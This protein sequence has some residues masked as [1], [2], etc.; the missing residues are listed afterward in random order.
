M[1]QKPPSKCFNRLL[2]W[3]GST[4][5][6]KG[7]VK[8]RP[9]L[10]CHPGVRIVRCALV[11]LVV[12]GTAVAPTVAAPPASSPQE[13]VDFGR[14][15][16]PILAN[17]CFDCHGPDAAQRESGLRLDEGESAKQPADSGEPAIVPGHSTQSELVRR[18]LSEDPDAVMP[19]VESNKRLTDVEKETLKRWIDAGAHYEVHWSFQKPMEP[20]LPR[21]SNDNWPRNEID[22]F[23]LRRLE[24][25]QLDP[26]AEADRVT[27]IRRLSLD[28]T[29]LPPSIAEVD[30]FLGDNN[31]NA[32]ARLVD[33]LLASPHYGEKMAEGWLDLARFGDTNG[34]QDDAYRPSWPYRDQVIAAFNQNQPFDQFT[35]ENLAGDLLPDATLSQQ[36]ASGFNRQHRQNE[37][38]GSDPDEF[39]VVYA[40][41]RTNTTATVWMGL[42]FGCGQCH[43]HKYDPFTQKEY[44]QLYAFFNSLDGEI[45]ISNKNPNS[46]P[47]QIRVPS[48]EQQVQ[49]RQFE[50]RIAQLNEQLEQHEPRFL[51]GFDKWLQ[52]EAVALNQQG[53]VTAEN[54]QLGVVGGVLT[55]SLEKS[56]YADIDLAGPLTFEHAFA[57]SGKVLIMSA[58]N[59]AVMVGHSNTNSSD[60]S[61]MLGISIESGPRLFARLGL[62]DGTDY[63]SDEIDVRPG[64]EYAWSYRWE[65]NAGQPDADK[66]ETR[67]QGVFT[68][69]LREQDKLVGTT[70][71]KLTAAQ[72]EVGLTLNA[73]GIV[74]I[75]DPD[76]HDESEL[77]LD[78]VEYVIDTAGNKRH[79][80]FDSE[81]N[82]A[83]LR[84]TSVGNRYGYDPEG[85][86]VTRDA[87]L[88][89]SVREILALAPEERS[90]KQRHCLRKQY[91]DAHDSVQTELID[92]RDKLRDE[93]ET[94]VKTL[95][96][97]LVMKEMQP[98]RP[99]HLLIRGDF[100]QPGE[101]VQPNVPAVFPPLP[102][103]RRPDRLALARWLVAKD[104]PLTA[105]VT[106]NR[107][108][109]QFFGEGL[110]RTMEDFGTR[111]ELPTHPEL[112][113]WLATQFMRDGW[114][115]KKLQ[116]RIVT[117]ETYRQSSAVTP[118]L[119]ERDPGNRLLA[120]GTRFRLSAEEIR[121]TALAV[122]GLLATNIGGPSVHPYQPAGFYGDKSLDWSWPS[123]LGSELYRRGLYTFLRRTTPYP[124][125][126]TFDAPSRGECAVSR[127]RTNTPLQALVTMNDPVFVE[128]SRVFAQ[129]VMQEGGESLDDRLTIA[130]RKVVARPPSDD[131]VTLLRQLYQ[132]RLGRYQADPTAALALVQ[133]G[134]A[135]RPEELKVDELA[136]WT[137]LGSLLLNLDETITRE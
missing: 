63:D 11:L 87:C 8:P 80:S 74:G 79:E 96:R 25:E 70:I 83:S 125:F 131:E 52:T 50:A 132:D 61:N 98:R 103:D 122:S 97:T 108:W 40:V 118:A 55:R 60:D 14:H 44:Y 88:V 100:Q 46:I 72:R 58:K 95:P 38:G 123:V 26:S 71:L 117:S 91:A 105:R 12:L 36:V 69:E 129:R 94:Y 111:G 134:K 73:F 67:P 39:R 126:Q 45:P 35:V 137:S 102:S 22:S 31:P 64:V 13:E 30:A 21:V 10:S 20:P 7:I 109:K 77:Y 104:H 86:T 47:P 84:T 16:L 19:P 128:A 92:R 17:N 68:V 106:V 114:N 99:A 66:G 27:Q 136:A 116:R 78:D 115:I 6:G 113:D 135:D 112:L 24:R 57:A 110:V 81:P 41:D 93:H 51:A 75:P 29:G 82:W 18:I 48:D 4:C 62:S 85:T 133:H 49:L 121:D 124:S 107:L 53:A 5:V 37:E 54:E 43:E 9:S 56:H 119:L 23:V 127:P 34:Y 32:Y 65:P 1:L 15:V 3:E 76:S 42:T 101:E 120:R 2:L 33:R 90:E 28:L 130:F 59:S 89:S